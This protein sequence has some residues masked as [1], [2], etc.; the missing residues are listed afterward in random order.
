[1]LFHGRQA[2]ELKGGE[3]TEHSIM[4]LATGGNLKESVRN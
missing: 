2:G 4:Y 3:M 1:V